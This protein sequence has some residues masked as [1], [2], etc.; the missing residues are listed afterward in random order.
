MLEYIICSDGNYLTDSEKKSPLE[1]LL[2]TYN[3]TST[4]DF[5]TRSEKN[6][7]TAID[8]IFIDTARNSYSMCPILM[9]CLIAMTSHQHLTQ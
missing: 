8:N 5:P 7:T 9:D 2:Q 6:S 3:L 4:V 1:A